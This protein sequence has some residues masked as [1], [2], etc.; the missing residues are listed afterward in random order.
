MQI[1][2]ARATKRTLAE[3]DS[4]QEDAEQKRDQ[5]IEDK[6]ASEGTNNEDFES[7][8]LAPFLVKS[9]KNLSITKPSPVQMACIPEII[10]GKHVIASAKTGSGKTAAFSLPIIHTLAS[11]PYG[12]YAL[13]LTPTRDLAFQIAEQI[14]VLGE[15]ASLKL[16]VVVG[17]V[18]IIRQAL[19]LSRRP[20]VV[21]A[22]PGRFADHLKYHA[23]SLFI[24]N[25]KYLVLDEADKLLSDTFAEH[26]EVIFDHLPSTRQTLLFSATM[27]EQIEA[28]KNKKTFVYKMPE[29]FNVERLEHRSILTPSMVRPCYLVW[30]LK[31]KCLNDKK[32]R[33]VVIFTSKCKTAETLRLLL[34]QMEF[35]VTSLHSQMSQSQRITSLSKFRS[36]LV[37]IL[38]T[39]DVGSRGLDIP[40]VDYVINYNI[41]N[42]AVDYIH[43][44]GR[45]ARA[46]RKGVC[47]SLIAENDADL[48]LNVEKKLGKKLEVDDV[49]ENEIEDMLLDVSK[50]QR[51]AHQLLMDMKFGEKKK[52]NQSKK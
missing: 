38:I 45:T 48:L 49:P 3:V 43:R 44:A 6:A 42:S 32:K 29:V 31:N 14:K 39:T 8:G 28:L 5:E 51:E 35:S 12:I 52:I 25:L 50:A 27:T 1:F 47:I 10:K 30:L 21:V 41:P 34:K 36:N 11:D 33:S 7:L 2:S 22:T 18:D 4:P 40:T 26:L 20:H 23:D 19:E 37:S 13:I 17:G 9:L 24:K 15:E 46:G 16:C